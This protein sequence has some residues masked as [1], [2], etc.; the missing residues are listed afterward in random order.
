VIVLA[1]DTALSATSVAVINGEQA[2]AARSEPMDRG[3][4]ERLGGLVRDVMAEA[5]V[6]FDVLARIGVT[7]GPGSFTGLRVGL[8]FAKVLALS[9]GIPCVGIGT[10][11]A[12]ALSLQTTDPIAAAIDARRGQ[13]Y[14]QLFSDGRALTDPAAVTVDDALAQ[15]QRFDGGPITAIGSGS[16]L[17]AATP[18]LSVSDRLVPEPMVLAF[19]A[20]RALQPI[21]RPEPL[22]LRAPDAKT[23]AERAAL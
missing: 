23:I 18:G 20:S 19:L 22:Y 1:L 15:L 3:H 13:I 11:E 12:L 21:V 4:Q 17:L 7:V 9:R 2:L 5:G 14:L 8:T 16:S 10:L 6:G